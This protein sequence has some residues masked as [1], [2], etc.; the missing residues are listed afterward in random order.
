M[1]NRLLIEFQE[2]YSYM[3]VLYCNGIYQENYIIIVKLLGSSETQG[4]LFIVYS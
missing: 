1:A 2:A 4:S 3:H